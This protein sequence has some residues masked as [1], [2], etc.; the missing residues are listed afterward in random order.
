MLSQHC[1]KEIWMFKQS[2]LYSITYCCTS[3]KYKSSFKML[4]ATNTWRKLNRCST[5]T[6]KEDAPR[7][8]KRT[9]TSCFMTVY[10]AEILKKQ[11]YKD[12]R[13]STPYRESIRI[14][15]PRQ[16]WPENMRKVW[17]ETEMREQARKER[18]IMCYRCRLLSG[19][20]VC[21]W[22]ASSACLDKQQ[23]H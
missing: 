21:V 7:C 3:T 18:I 4:Y 22:S 13:Y 5:D 6:H 17:W 19:V 2:D 23:L 16:P 20:I 11:S 15:P 10:L 8:D 9:I 12:N 1:C 14:C